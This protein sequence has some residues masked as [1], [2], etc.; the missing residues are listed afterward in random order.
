MSPHQIQNRIGIHIRIRIRCPYPEYP[1]YPS[2][3]DI[4]TVYIFFYILEPNINIIFKNINIYKYIY[5]IYAELQY[6][7]YISNSIEMIRT[8]TAK[9]SKCPS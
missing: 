2:E 5:N 8:S 3:D 7:T 1:L 9:R 6:D 4:Y